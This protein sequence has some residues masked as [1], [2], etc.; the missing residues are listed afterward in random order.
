MVEL[1]LDFIVIRVI[2]DS[3]IVNVVLVLQSVWV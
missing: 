2:V 1:G 3:K